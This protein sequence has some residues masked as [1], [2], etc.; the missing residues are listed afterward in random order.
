VQIQVSKTFFPNAVDDRGLM[1][2]VVLSEAIG[3]P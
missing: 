2:A 1:E 3:R